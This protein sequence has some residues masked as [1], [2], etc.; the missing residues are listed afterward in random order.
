MSD[1]ADKVEALRYLR[2]LNEMLKSDAWKL[3]DKHWEL[4]EKG[5]QDKALD[6]KLMA[7]TRAIALGVY[8]GIKSMRLYA[9]VQLPNA[10]KTAAGVHDLQEER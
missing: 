5:N 9:T 8:K 2:L 10:L 1:E 3:L 4:Q 7:D 6:E